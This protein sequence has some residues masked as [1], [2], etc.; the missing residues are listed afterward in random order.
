MTALKGIFESIC[1]EVECE[2]KPKLSGFLTGVILRGNLP[3]HWVFKTEKETVTFSV[4]SNGNASVKT[5]GKS[6]PDVTIN[7]DHDYLTTALTTRSQPSFSPKKLKTKFHTTK[8][9]RAFTFL[10]GRF[11]L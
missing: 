7:V 1:Y 6:K 3:Q 9:E 4:D 8:G 10:R 2:V 11:G 5:G